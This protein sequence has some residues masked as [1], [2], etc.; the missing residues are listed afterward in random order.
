M[1]IRITSNQYS[2]IKENYLDIDADKIPD[3]GDKII[4]VPINNPTQR[5]QSEINYSNLYKDLWKEM[6]HGVCM[7]YTNDINTA[8]DYCQN[9]FVKVYNNLTK[10][11]GN[12]GSLKGWV[13]KVI[14]NNII[15]EIRK[16][17]LQYTNDEPD[18]GRMDIPVGE[19]YNEEGIS[20]E[21]LMRVAD[22]L[23]PK[24]KAVF[25]LYAQG[26]KHEEIA[27]E[28]GIN[29]GTSKSNLYKAKAN[30][31]KWLGK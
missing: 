21:D 14:G 19:E 11:S 6:L 5:L 27:D 22:R 18:W 16:K 20:V 13:K 17:K 12:K 28:L 24:F 1:K 8:Q 9:G 15:D 23:S 30:I 4:A 29:I 10:F 2:L 26:Y 25:D 31:R 3:N 7:K